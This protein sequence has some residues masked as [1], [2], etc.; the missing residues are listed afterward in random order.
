[1]YRVDPTLSTIAVR[2]RHLFGLG[3]IHGTFT[4]HG[5][6]IVVA[7]R[8]E[9]SLVEAT[10]AAASFNS[11]NPGRD[12]RVGS[13]ALLNAR[14]DPE[15]TFTSHQVVKTGSSWT[16]H[17]TLTARGHGAPCE[18][19]VV[20]TVERP[21]GF[22][23]VAIGT[24]DRYAHGITGARGLAARYLDVTVTLVVSTVG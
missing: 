4:L 2:T 5:G 24:I 10:A 23:V 6:Q 12:K 8:V 22:E 18:F 19:A 15:I 16:A 7:E 20:D 9:D 3:V 13:K 1:V 21:D 14:E 17:G 11:G